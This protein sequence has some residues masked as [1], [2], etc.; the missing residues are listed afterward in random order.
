M[1]ATSISPLG[2]I[3]VAVGDPLARAFLADN[4]HADGYQPLAVED[5]EQALWQLEGGDVDALLADVG[6][7]TPDLLNQIRRQAHPAL[8]PQLPVL[9]LAGGDWLARTRLLERGA[10]DVIAKPYS[11]PE[12]RARLAALLRRSQARRAPHVLRA[13]SLRLDTRS[14]QANIAG[15]PIDE[16]PG[17]EYQL[18]LT[19]LTDPSRVFTRQELLRDI[20]GHGPTSRTRT[21]DSHAARLRKR[22]A[23]SQEKFVHCVWGIGYRLTDGAPALDQT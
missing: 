10:D 12:L 18:L 21:L 8:D 9:A 17:K 1:S 7:S 23:V 11:Y 3:V 14:R 19:L 16:L 2:S 6:R 20:W 22:L 4:L 15:I 5:A 13:G